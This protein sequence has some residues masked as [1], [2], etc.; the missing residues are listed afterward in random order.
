MNSGLRHRA[1]PPAIQRHL[2]QPSTGLPALAGGGAFTPD[3]AMAFALAFAAAFALALTGGG[4]TDFAMAAA[5]AFA[6][7]F[8]SA[9]GGAFGPAFAS[10]IALAF[11]SAIALVFAKAFALADG[12]VAAALA[13]HPELMQLHHPPR[14]ALSLQPCS[15]LAILS[16]R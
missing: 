15:F 8:A 4:A 12:G 13:P 6:S 1:Q 11:A 2:L 5:L 14:R 9:G 10:A 7:A 3:F 16:V